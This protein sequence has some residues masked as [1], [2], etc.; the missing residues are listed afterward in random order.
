MCCPRLRES[1]RKTKKTPERLETSLINGYFRVGQ[2]ETTR[3]A[4]SFWISEI[5]KEYRNE[6]EELSMCRF[7][8]D[9]KLI[10]DKNKLA[11]LQ[12]S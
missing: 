9:K 6:N 11:W 3:V 10:T 12:W 8:N 1:E 4:Q 2:K 5:S 7:E